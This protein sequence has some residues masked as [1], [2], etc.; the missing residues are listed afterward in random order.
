MP[1]YKLQ[2]LNL[3][4]E[5]EALQATG[6]LAAETVQLDQTR[7]GRLSRMDALQ[8]QAM[9]KASNARRAKKIRDIDKALLRIAN[10][11]YG[12]CFECEEKINPKRLELNLTTL[13][14]IECA[15]RLE[16]S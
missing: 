3:R 8:Q 15:Q 4:E 5:L 6:M 7:Q 1:E 13:Y 10:K 2:L 12:F 14:C 16:N 9:S 11:E